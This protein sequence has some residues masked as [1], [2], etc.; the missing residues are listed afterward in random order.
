MQWKEI[1]ET[2]TTAMVKEVW[3]CP[4]SE[5]GKGRWKI[6]RC[7]V[8]EIKK[9]AETIAMEVLGHPLH[10]HDA[11]LYFAKMLY[12]HFV[13]ERPV[14]FSSK[15][16]P[17]SGAIDFKS[18]SITLTKDELQL[19]LEGAKLELKEQ[20]ELLQRQLEEKERERHNVSWRL[21]PPCGRTNA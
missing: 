21:Q 2:V 11:P 12:M 3:P 10:N 14:D 20:K 18:K 15:E 4:D 13:L 9:N 19:A 7:R 6:S 17:E 16:A 8:D 5:T 1:N